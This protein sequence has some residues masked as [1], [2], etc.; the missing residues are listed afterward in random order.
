MDLRMTI[1]GQDDPGQQ[2]RGDSYPDREQAFEADVK[3]GTS[4]S[5]GD[6]RGRLVEAAINGDPQARES[7]IREQLGWI[8]QAAGQRAGRGLS[9]GDLVQEGSL[10]L[11]KAIDEF[12]G[13]G[14]TDFEA[15]AR[16]QISEQMEQAIAQEDSAQEESRRLVQAAEDYQKAEFAL[17]RELGRDA[18]PAEL[19]AK[20]EWPQHRTDGIADMVAEARRRHDEE[21]LD[22]LDP[23]DLDLDRLLG[24]A[25]DSADQGRS[26]GTNGG[27]PSSSQGPTSN[28]R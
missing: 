10:G 24:D 7:L 11:M 13:S 26:K 3:R 14:G 15:F 18:T 27:A 23:E 16:E 1:R 19:A 22:Y 6:D 12:P 20:L 17:K 2:P 9:E 28:E 4:A 5:R 8:Q 21:L 25:E